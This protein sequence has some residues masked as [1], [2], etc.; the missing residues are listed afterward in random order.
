MMV[1]KRLPAL[2]VLVL[3][4]HVGLGGCASPAEGR[5]VTILGPWVG[6]E[7]APVDRMRAE[8]EQRTGIETV[9]IGS[10]AVDQVLQSAVQQ[11]SPP[12]IAVLPGPGE[13]ARYRQALAGTGFGPKPLDGIVQED[14]AEDY[15]AQWRALA[16]A[17]MPELLAVPAKVNLKGMVWFPTQS[18]P[19]RVPRTFEEL[20]ALGREVAAG[21]ATP[22]CMGVSAQSTS[23]WPGTD[24]IESILLH[25]SGMDVYQQWAT[26][27]LPWTSPEVR[28]AWTTWGQVV[29]EPGQVRG[30]PT[31]ALLTEFGDAARPMFAHEPGCRMEHQA[32]FMTGFYAGYG[33]RDDD[34]PQPGTDFDFFLFPPFGAPPADPA[35]Q[36]RAVAADM[37]SMFNH[38]PEAEAFVRFLVS[39][40]A[41]RHWPAATMFSASRGVTEYDPFDRRIA[42]E[43]T[44]EAPLCF[45]ASDLMPAAV[46][47]AFYR[48]V[49]EYLSD[50]GRLDFLLGELERVRTEVEADHWLTVA[51]GTRG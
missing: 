30:G 3:V 25:R 14:W 28:G 47:G 21:G 24:W 18:P 13:A 48:A 23:G 33:E 11:G 20:T 31:A 40:E 19:A 38:T 4:A 39:E 26:G 12:D 29:A 9:Y 46:R 22:W 32:S 44:G 6:P 50:P 17:G 45:D 7:A 8:F 37:A 36:P 34:H 35:Q 1:T 43:L 41:Q 51:C 10:S 42:A 5:R 16:T 2:L 49:L 27:A 15:S